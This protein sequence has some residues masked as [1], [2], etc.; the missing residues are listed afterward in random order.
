MTD[1]TTVVER[2]I[3]EEV[4]IKVPTEWGMF[5]EKGNALITKYATRA[6]DA[7]K[8]Y[9]MSR[10]GNPQYIC[11][12]FILDTLRLGKQKAHAE[13]QDTDVREQVASFHDRMFTAMTGDSFSA[14]AM[15]EKNHAAAY[16]VAY[17][18]KIKAKK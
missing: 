8:Q 18:R 5:T 10:E 7:A 17:E 1:L 14:Y 11:Y 16:A 4:T 3:R 6:Y 9:Q 12:Q 13:V 15:W 2:T